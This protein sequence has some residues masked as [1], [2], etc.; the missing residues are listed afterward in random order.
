MGAGRLE[1]RNS[2]FA[3]M[4]N[5]LDSGCLLEWGEEFSATLIMRE[6]VTCIR[7]NLPTS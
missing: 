4:R 2:R 3:D 5:R 1:L 6:G 7:P